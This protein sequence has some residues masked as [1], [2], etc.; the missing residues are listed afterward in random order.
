MAL[1]TSEQAPQLSPTEDSRAQ[2]RPAGICLH[3]LL[4][5]GPGG[6]P[7]LFQPRPDRPHDAPRERLGA[8]N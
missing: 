5:P 3:P 8:L 2:G 1:H 4:E 6:D 7:Q